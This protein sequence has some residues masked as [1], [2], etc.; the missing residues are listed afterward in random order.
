M[1]RKTLI[2]PDFIKVMHENTTMDDHAV[3]LLK[4][5]LTRTKNSY[6]EKIE[7]HS[8]PKGLYETLRD[9]GIDE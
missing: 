2:D 1:K 6:K 3:V 5:K 7:M 8:L 9:W 4:I